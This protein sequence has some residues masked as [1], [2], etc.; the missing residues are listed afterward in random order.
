MLIALLG[1]NRDE[2]HFT[3]PHRFDV[4]R[5]ESRHIAFGHGIHHCVGAPLARMEG[6]VALDRLLT[7]YDD[8]RLAATDPLIY[9]PSTLMR[10]LQALPVSLR[11]AVIRT[12]VSADPGADEPTRKAC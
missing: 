2:R 10:G 11:T 1:A 8:I 4:F 3:E 9:R 6:E 5:P 12:P 7:R